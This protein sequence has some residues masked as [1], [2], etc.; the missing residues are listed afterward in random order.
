[1][2]IGDAKANA[3]IVGDGV[4]MPKPFPGTGDGAAMPKSFPKS[5][6]WPPTAS[7]ALACPDAS[8]DGAAG[9]RLQLVRFIGASRYTARAEE[10][11]NTHLSGAQGAGGK[12]HW[13]PADCA[14]FQI[15]PLKSDNP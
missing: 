15:F 2:K 6:P 12:R 9:L 3:P 7:G 11:A 8:P 5:W 14:G 10:S 4:A 1:M 13:I